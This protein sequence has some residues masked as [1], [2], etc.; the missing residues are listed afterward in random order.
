MKGMAAAKFAK[1]V[2][3]KRA[4][5][6][7]LNDLKHDVENA[8]SKVVTNTRLLETMPQEALKLKRKWQKIRSMNTTGALDQQAI[9][10]NRWEEWRDGMS[11][12]NARV[13]KLLET[14]GPKDANTLLTAISK[15]KAGLHVRAPA[16]EPCPLDREG[17]SKLGANHSYCR[18]N[19]VCDYTEAGSGD[20]CRHTKGK[21]RQEIQEA[22]TISSTW[23]EDIE[24]TDLMYL[25]E[26][27]ARTKL[28]RVPK[29]PGK[30]YAP[31][32]E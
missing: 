31:T 18:K 25:S 7:K 14:E 2:G 3:K 28:V 20:G 6:S 9:L 27:S 1:D 15:A 26:N 5:V 23:N 19:N 22:E 16:A 12:Y 8:S 13:E 10:N 32:S 30:Q 11:E 24:D 29:K 21:L 4:Y 17:R